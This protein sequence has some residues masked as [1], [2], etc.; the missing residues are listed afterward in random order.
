M[1]K[2]PISEKSAEILFNRFLLQ[3]FPL[4]R[5]QLFAPTSFEEFRNG[6]D[7]R[8]VGFSSFRELYLQF[9]A[10]LYSESRARFTV[11]ATAH[12]HRLLKSYPPRSAYYVAPMFKSLAE[13]NAAQSNLHTAA[14][15]L[16]N[17][18]CIEVAPLPTELDF[19][20][21]VQPPS[22]RESPQVKYKTPG[23]GQTRTAIHPVNGDGWLRGSTLLTK[24]KANEIG[25][26][27]DLAS[28][29]RAAAAKDTLSH[30]NTDI[31][32]VAE[33]LPSSEF[34]VLVR[35]PIG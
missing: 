25:V 31:L 6:Y 20:H 4:G 3:S 13:L 15:F 23:D 27:C 24:F 21:Y 2:R 22:H 8:V 18:V 17:F 10:P 16:K 5:V 32:H 35:T 11:S 19:F 12:Q 7:A 28:D 33:G 30:Q 26:R 34:P 9:K 29:Y 1:N 14:D